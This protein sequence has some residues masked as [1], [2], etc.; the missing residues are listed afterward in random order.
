MIQQTIQKDQLRKVL[1]PLSKIFPYKMERFLEGKL[2]QSKSTVFVG[3]R[4]D[5]Y[6]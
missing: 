5:N 1:A 2:T 3:N 4:G 6:K